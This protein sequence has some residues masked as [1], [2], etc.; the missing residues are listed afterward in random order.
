MSE[1]EQTYTAIRERYQTYLQTVHQ[2]YGPPRKSRT[3]DI[4]VKLPPQP[5][6]RDLIPKIPRGVELVLSGVKTASIIYDKLRQVRRRQKAKD[7]IQGLRESINFID[8]QLTSDS[9]EYISWAELRE[10]R[11]WIEQF[12]DT[13]RRDLLHET[14]DSKVAGVP[15]LVHLSNLAL[16]RL[17]WQTVYWSNLGLENVRHNLLYKPPHWDAERLQFTL[18]EVY[19]LVVDG[20]LR[21]K[22]WA[23]KIAQAL[24]QN[25]SHPT[26]VILADGFE[27]DENEPWPAEAHFS[28]LVLTAPYDFW[29]TGQAPARPVL[30]AMAQACGAQVV[31]FGIDFDSGKNPARRSISP[32][33]LGRAAWVLVDRQRVALLPQKDISIEVSDALPSASNWQPRRLRLFELPQSWREATNPDLPEILV[34]WRIELEQGAM[35][36]A[37]AAL[38]RLGLALRAQASSSA[39]SPHELVKRDFGEA[40]QEPLRLLLARAVNPNSSQWAEM[41]DWLAEPRRTFRLTDDGHFKARDDAKALAL[42]TPLLELRRII[43]QA[44][45]AL[46]DPRLNEPNEG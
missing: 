39:A 44:V 16:P 15:F 33:V 32:E 11:T 12:S 38:Y 30:Q 4:Y 36:G 34:H 9:P 43:N 25:S 21:G 42:M 40:L 27:I 3:D 31:D 1:P 24:S 45:Q 8:Q 2:H 28:T 19:V 14:F 5:E 23:N 46:L 18:D 7:F 13:R 20:V 6:A 17:T 35:A 37:G 22:M 29:D 26:L 41:M 10:E